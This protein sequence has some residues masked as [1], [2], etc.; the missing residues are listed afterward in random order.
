MDEAAGILNGDGPLDDFGR[1]L[2][3]GWKPKRSISENIS[4]SRIDEIYDTARKAGVVGGEALGAGGGV[5]AV[6]RSFGRPETGP[7]GAEVA[8]PRA[9]PVR[10]SR[11]PDHPLHGKRGRRVRIPFGTVEITGTARRLIGEI[12]ET[13][14]V[15]S[16]KYVREFEKRFADL[17][18]TRE[19][20]AVSTGTDADA[21]ALAVLHDFGARRGRGDHARP[22]LRFYGQRRSAGRLPARFRRYL[23]RHPQYRSV[24]DRG[25][26]HRPNPRHHARPPDGK[27]ADMDG[28]NAIASGRGII[29]VEDAAEA[30]GAVYK[31]K[32]PGRLGRWAPSACTSPTSSPPSRGIVTTDRDDYAEVLRSLRSHG[33]ACSC[34]S[35]VL[36]T[37]T[38]S[39]AKRF[40][41]GTDIRFIFE[42]VGFSAKMNELEAAVGLGSLERYGGR[43]CPGGGITSTT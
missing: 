14:R 9:V 34:E 40:R 32:T 19:A 29:V 5:H 33:R 27:P 41:Y 28:I 24:A 6:L 12:L 37:D 39:C 20:V 16:G 22:D 26:D 31:G 35:C 15:S 25:G 4:T 23:P 1:L 13:G 7:G 2:D 11:E 10:V 21:L 43:S 38:G 42:R 18:G 8:A 30:H 3:Q 36:N 17:V